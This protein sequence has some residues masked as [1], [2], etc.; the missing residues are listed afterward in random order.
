MWFCD[1]C[2]PLPLQEVQPRPSCCVLA[3]VHFP[4]FPSSF[5]SPQ[6]ALHAPSCSTSPRGTALDPRTSSLKDIIPRG[7]ASAWCPPSS[8]WALGQGAGHR[9]TPAW[10]WPLCGSRFPSDDW[11]QLWPRTAQRLPG[12]LLGRPLPRE[13]GGEGGW[14]PCDSSDPWPLQAARPARAEGGQAT[15]RAL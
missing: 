8:T 6:P 9:G 15:G 13:R 3:C 11:K 5:P 2:C 1:D 7:S 10:P 14:C 4:H 12:G